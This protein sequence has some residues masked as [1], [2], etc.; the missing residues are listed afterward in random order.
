MLEALGWGLL[1]QSSLLIAGLLVCWVTVPTK[2][3][4]TWTTPLTRMLQPARGGLADRNPPDRSRRNLFGD[5]EQCIQLYVR[6][7][8]PA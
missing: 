6:G 1:A 2:L 4:G 8:K 7:G 5:A 3:V